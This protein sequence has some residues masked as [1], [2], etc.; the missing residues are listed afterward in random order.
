MMLIASKLLAM[1]S[2][3][4]RMSRSMMLRCGGQKGQSSEGPLEGDTQDDGAAILE[5]IIIVFD[6]GKW[7]TSARFTLVSPRSMHENA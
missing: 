3:E 7:R 6:E 4:R 2:A 1:P 5:D